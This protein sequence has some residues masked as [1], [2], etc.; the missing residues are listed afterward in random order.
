MTTNL[1]QTPRK[2]TPTWPR[3]LML[4]SGLLALSIGL[5]WV[6]SGFGGISSWYSFLAVVTLASGI[7]LGGYWSLRNENPPDWLGKLLLAAALIRLAAGIFWFLVLPLWGHGSPAE[8]GGY[9]MADAGSRD[10]AAWELA[11][12]NDSLWTAFRGQRKVDQYGGLLFL[13][14]LAYR[15][16]GADT[17]QPLMMVVLA[18]A[19]SALA[20][21]FTWA[22]A[23]RAW[24]L[25]TAR[26]AA[27]V[28]ALYPEAI[29]LGSSQMREAFTTTLVVAS[30]YGL[31]RYQQAGSSSKSKWASLAWL[32]VPVALCLPFSPPLAALLV[33]IL[34]VSV[35]LMTVLQYK[36]LPRMNTRRV[37]LRRQR[38]IWV[39]L[40]LM[41]GVVLV[42]LWLALGQFTPEGMSNPLAMLGWWLRK[43]SDLQAHYSKH[44]SGL[45]QYIFD[46]TPAW[47]H[48]PM[49]IGYGIVQPFLPAAL[50]VPSL[51][52]IWPWITMLRAVGWT[53]MLIFLI[54]SPVLA[55]RQEERTSNQKRAFTLALIAIVWIG[56]LIASYRG[57][58]D[59][60]DNP[61]YRAVFA[62]LQS[63]LVAW[64]WVTHRRDPT[65]WLR[66]IFFGVAGFVIWLVPWF[67]RRYTAFTW[68][69]SNIMI[70]LALGFA[71]ACLLII[72]DW[73]RRRAGG[74]PPDQKPPE[75]TA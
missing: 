16:L 56:I 27:W 42:G 69:I 40:I 17:H 10:Q 13:S 8:R 62:G 28:M 46:R 37:E 39:I 63:A 18:S 3:W 24:D 47:T 7:L 71:T 29:L 19:F 65:P 5:A 54:Y 35:I 57:G 25:Q 67:I 58:G 12:S 38:W 74:N 53:L 33:G 66:R 20:V 48:L 45:I 34:A 14:G 72:W 51:S 6:S 41:V 64:T 49:L 2:R 26:L 73:A 59:L 30:F 75:Q 32:A 15:Y 22:M 36:A 55:W 1:G 68:P 4:L 52:P 31:L 21:P 60:W 61:R 50:A 11:G 44:A 23:R 70:T 9:I 43:S